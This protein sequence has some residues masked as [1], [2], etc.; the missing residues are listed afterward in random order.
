M[1]RSPIEIMIDQAT[2]YDPAKAKPRKPMVLL[3]CPKCKRRQKSPLEPDDPPGTATV[4]IQCPKC[5][6]GDFDLPKYQ[7]AAGNELSADPK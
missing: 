1:V 5:I 3:Y 6:G 4:I 2:G 7:D